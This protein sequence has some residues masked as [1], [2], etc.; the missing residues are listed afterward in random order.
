MKVNITSTSLRML[1]LVSLQIPSDFRNPTDPGLTDIGSLQGFYLICSVTIASFLCLLFMILA[2]C[3]LVPLALVSFSP[4][5]LSAN[6]R[7]SN[8]IL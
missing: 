3:G 1:N 2:N 7:A 5:Y 6:K 4:S 8:V